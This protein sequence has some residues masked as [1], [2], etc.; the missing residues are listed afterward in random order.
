MEK[1]LFDLPELAHE[2]GTS[3]ET[4]IRFGSAGEFS[5]YV[6]AIE[7]PGKVE[8]GKAKGSEITVDQLVALDRTDLLKALNADYTT[9]RKVIIDDGSIVGLEPSRDV[10]R[11]VHFVTAEDRR[12]LKQILQPMLAGHGD[13]LPAY[14]DDSHEYYSSTLAAAVGVWLALFNN[15]GFADS[16]SPRGQIDA[17]LRRH[18]NDLSQNARDSITTVV[19]PNMLK[20]GGARQ[21]SS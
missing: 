13:R 11:G 17:W 9:V 1:P 2:L 14:L 18:R 8:A 10:M 5:V 6:I 3:V 20:R 4:L 16:S 15:N 7:W 19:N 21:E 12:R